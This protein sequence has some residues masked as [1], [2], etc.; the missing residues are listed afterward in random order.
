ML[1]MSTALTTGLSF[2]SSLA[3]GFGAQQSAKD[4]REE[5]EEMYYEA[6]AKNKK[7]VV[8]YNKKVK[9]QYA[10]ANAA[11]IERADRLAATP[12]VTDRTETDERWDETVGSVD[13]EAMMEGARKAGFNPVT[14][15]QAGGMQA[16]SRSKTTRG[17]SITSHETETGN[18]GLVAAQ[19]EAGRNIAPLAMHQVPQFGLPY[20][21]PSSAEVVGDAVSNAADTFITDYRQGVQNDLSRELLGMQLDAAQQKGSAGSSSRFGS[22]PSR[23][24]TSSR[25]GGGGVGS[26]GSGNLRSPITTDQG[27]SERSKDDTYTPSKPGRQEVKFPGLPDSPPGLPGV[28]WWVS[29]PSDNQERI[30]S[31]YG[32]GPGEGYGWLRT[33]NDAIDNAIRLSEEYGKKFR[34]NRKFNPNTKYNYPAYKTPG[35][36][37]KPLP[38]SK[39][40]W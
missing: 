34:T 1:G 9:K 19:M 14:W 32:D 30:E 24:T 39:F 26:L 7:G 13:T 35:K 27:W 37:D 31:D 23:K 5:D 6:N 3:S 36:G 40:T 11:E 28:P 16:Y 18:P 8:E 12:H 2:A 20:N 33:G 15:L 21:V 4:A 22:T 25:G 38:P 29:S 17:G 10:E